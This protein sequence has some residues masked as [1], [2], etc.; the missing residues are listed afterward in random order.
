[1]LLQE[2]ESREEEIRRKVTVAYQK[3]QEK[4][5][6]DDRLIASVYGLYKGSWRI[7][8][9]GLMAIVSLVL[10][11]FIASDFISEGDWQCTRVR[12]LTTDTCVG[13]KEELLLADFYITIENKEIPVTAEMFLAL[14]END[15]VWV[16]KTFYL[17][18]LKTIRFQEIISTPQGFF[19]D[20][21][22][23]LCVLLLIPLLSFFFMKRT[24][25]FV[26]F[27]VHFNLYVQPLLIAYVLLGNGRVFHMI[28]I[29]T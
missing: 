12:N 14:K 23:V 28:S 10:C 2:E 17:G 19:N 24:F 29:L 9:S 11:F 25:V 3:R 16:E 13:N 22:V 4:R 26:F 1:M 5:E 7:Y 27:F 20:A 21:W 15:V 8:I 6:A 18:E